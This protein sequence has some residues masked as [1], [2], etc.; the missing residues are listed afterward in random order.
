MGIFERIRNDILEDIQ[1]FS[2]E[3][4]G[5]V[6]EII[7]ENDISISIHENIDG[8]DRDYVIT[9]PA[10]INKQWIMDRIIVTKSATTLEY[11]IDIERLSEW[12]ANSIDRNML[13]T[14]DRI[15]ITNNSEDDYDY[16]VK[17]DS[18]FKY[19]L[20]VSDLPYEN[21]VGYMWYDYQ[22]VFVNMSAIENTVNEMIED[23][24]IYAQEKDDEI[25]L[26]I[27]MTV[28]H[29]IRHLA[30]ANP[31]LPDALLQQTSDDETDAE[32]FAKKCV[33]KESLYVI[34]NNE[35]VFR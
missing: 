35:S 23:G 12:I 6:V 25:N 4:N 9:N 2:L 26:G 10:V 22:M 34:A 20:E 21:I 30:Q 8:H 17:T 15:I 27:I 3:D 24:Y 32:E 19:M 5:D 7:E 31:Y 13:M 16:L 29:E 28:A 18:R 1:Q 33:T 11:Q 14:L